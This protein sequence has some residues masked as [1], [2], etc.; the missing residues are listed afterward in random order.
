[1]AG[2]NNLSPRQRMINLMYIILTA[3]LALNVSSDVLN[4]FK[5]VEDGLSHSTQNVVQ[6]NDVLYY[7]IAEYYENNP[8][9]AAEWY[10]KSQKLKQGSDSIYNMVERLKWQIVRYA[11]GDNA[12]VEKINHREDLQAASFIMLSP[13]HN[14]G[15]QLRL[16]LDKY[17]ESLVSMI[18][19]TAKQNITNRYLS[20]DPTLLAD[21]T[22]ISWEESMFSH[23]P[24]SAAITLLIKIQSDV[25]YAEGEILHQLIKNVDLGDLRVNQLSTFVIPNTKNVIRGGKYS[26]NIVLAAIDSTQQPNIF[27]NG[28]QL[29]ESQQGLYEVQ[30][31]QSGSYNYTGYLEVPRTDGTITRHEFES[32][33]TVVDPSAT[34]S[35]TLM[36][37]LYAGID[38]PISISVPGVPSQQVQ[39]SITNGTLTRKGNSW[40]AKPTHIGTETVIK[41]TANIDGAS[42]VVANTAFR[43]RQLP[44]PVPYIAFSDQNGVQQRYK[45]GKPLSK[46]I[47]LATNGIEAALDDDLLNVQ[48]RVISFETIFFDSMGNAMPEV[49]DGAN[50]SERQKTAFRRLSRGKRFYISRVRAIGPDGVERDLSPLEVII[51]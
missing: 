15:K 36:N 30:C 27:I 34:V 23:V 5:L 48:Y 31:H 9:K 29:P 1:M 43:V 45:G 46:T 21:K 10:H 42:Q 20:T 3:M 39:A 50:F 12:D 22:S 19:D 25:R 7:D 40:V 11:D 51:G 44:D 6:Q 41:V 17:R 18:P 24:V 16:A 8:E 37:V 4:G 2:S 28:E 35:A 26:A 49:S 38:N 13:A 14:E 33:Y 47:L 32:T